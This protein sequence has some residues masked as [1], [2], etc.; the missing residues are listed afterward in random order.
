MLRR[1][2]PELD[3]FVEVYVTSFLTWDILLHFHRH[4]Q[5]GFAADDLALLLG[6]KAGDVERALRDLTEKDVLECDDSAYRL[7]AAG[8]LRDSIDKFVKALHNRET[9]LNVLTAVLRNE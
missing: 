3:R 2:D 6:R 9:R 5:D 8:E 4:E 1:L 7:C